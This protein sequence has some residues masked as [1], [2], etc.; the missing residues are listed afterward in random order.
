MTEAELN[1]KIAAIDK[2]LSKLS[3]PRGEGSIAWKNKSRCYLEYK[4]PYKFPDGTSKRITAY[5]Y[6]I[7][8]VRENMHIKEAEELEKWKA[9]NIPSGL[10]N[11][12]DSQLDNT[13]EESMKYWFYNFNHLNKRGRTFDREEQTLINQ[14]LKYTLLSKTQMPAITDKILQE[15][16]NE[17]MKKYSY[18]TVKKTYELLD[19][20][21]G[22]YYSKNINANPMNTVVKPREID[23]RKTSGRTIKE[24][25]YFTPEEIERFIHEATAR[26]STGKR[27][28]KFGDGLVFMMYTGLRFGEA[29]GLTWSDISKDWK[30]I[31]I[32]QAQSYELERDKDRK[33]TGRRIRIKDNPKTKAGIRKVYLIAQAKMYLQRLKDMQKPESDQEYIFATSKHAQA[34]SYYNL[35]RAFKLICKNC[36]ITDVDESIGLHSLRHTFVSML[37][38]KHIDKM[39]V[40]SIV[41]QSDTKMI[42]KVYYHVLQEEKDAALKALESDEVV[43]ESIVN[44][45]EE[46]MSASQLAGLDV[47][48]LVS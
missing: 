1:K 4:K 10:N 9:S 13:L 27:I 30:Y 14:V 8:D 31:N 37:C 45:G 23:V 2:K 44:A 22:Y 11:Q 7:D 33:S 6:D 19:Q 20:F 29:V 12:A 41:G 43:E 21:F 38:R 16:F 47:D 28:Y 36:G 40:A 26:Y 17:L 35:M 34:V 5:G 18:S 42:E 25:R 15:H 39:V 3:L 24:I 48:K 46:V 32:S